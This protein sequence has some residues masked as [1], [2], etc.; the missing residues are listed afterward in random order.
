MTNG[1]KRLSLVSYA[2]KIKPHEK[3]GPITTLLAPDRIKASV[4]SK[5]ID[6]IANGFKCCKR[7]PWIEYM[8][9]QIMMIANERGIYTLDHAL[10]SDLLIKSVVSD[11]VKDAFTMDALR[12]WRTLG[13]TRFALS[14][15]LEEVGSLPIFLNPYIILNDMGKMFTILDKNSPLRAIRKRTL[16]H[17]IQLF[18][19]YDRKQYYECAVMQEGSFHPNHTLNDILGVHID[20]ND[21]DELKRSIRRMSVKGRSWETICAEGNEVLI[22]GEFLVTFTSITPPLIVDR[23]YR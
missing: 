17:V 16:Y 12:S 2:D 15:L 13:Y 1:N 18:D 23:L 19:N 3:G 21:W 8:T 7:E 6:M 4:T 10:M 11:S 5:F 22:P 14:D 9:E 20:D